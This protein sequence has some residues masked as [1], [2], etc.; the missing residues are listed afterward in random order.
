[1]ARN[2]LI[3]SGI[4][5]LELTGQNLGQD[6]SSSSGRM[7]VMHELYHVTKTAKLKVENLA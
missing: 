7:H 1:M 5:K 4:D 3:S 6:C 2:L